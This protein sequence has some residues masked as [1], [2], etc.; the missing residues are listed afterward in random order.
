MEGGGAVLSALLVC[1][2][3]VFRVVKLRFR[4]FLCHCERERGNQMCWY[5]TC[6]IA[7]RLAPLAMTKGVRLNPASISPS[8]AEG[9]GG[10]S[11]RGLARSNQRAK[12]PQ[13]KARAKL[14]RSHSTA[15][16]WILLS[17]IL[18]CSSIIESPATAHS[19]NVRA[20]GITLTH[21]LWTIDI[22]KCN[23]H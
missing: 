21:A 19:G 17:L 15:P 5:L 7:T 6:L 12:N 16:L 22:C 23:A 2:S 10:G 9:A 3:H 13:E 14:W 8:L 20:V 18:H 1:D 4:Y 11:L